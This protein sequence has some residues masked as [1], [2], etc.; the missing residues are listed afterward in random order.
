MT[1]RFCCR[2]RTHRTATDSADFPMSW[3]SKI[4]RC[5][6]LT[7]SPTTVRDQQPA[8]YD[9]GKGA[10]WSSASTFD[11]EVSVEDNSVSC[12]SFLDRFPATGPLNY[13]ARSYADW[14]LPGPGLTENLHGQRHSYLGP[15]GALYIRQ[16]YSSESQYSRSNVIVYRGSG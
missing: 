2:L 11:E 14:V 9:R 10:S 3:L 16:E 6:N 8:Q 13:A 15:L 7:D 1:I 12:A 5:F 4:P